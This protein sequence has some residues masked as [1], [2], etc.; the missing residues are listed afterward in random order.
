MINRRFLAIPALL[1]LALPLLAQRPQ[2]RMVQLPIDTPQALLGAQT[3]SHKAAADVLHLAISLPFADPAGAQQFADSVSDPSS[4]NYRQFAT[5]EEIGRRFGLSEANVKKVSD[6]L[7]SQGM[8]VT[9]VGKNRLSI[10][11]DATVGQAEKAFGVSIGNFKPKSLKVDR[12]QGFFSYTT[13]P[14]LPADIAPYVIDIAGLENYTR[15]QRRMF[16]TP[17]QIRSV[18][19]IKPMFDAGF[20]GEGRN[21]AISN[22]DGFRLSNIAPFLTQFG[23]PAPAAGAATNVT[24][25]TIDGGSGTGTQQGEAD[26]D[27]QTILAIAPLCNLIIYDGVNNPVNVLTLETNDNLADII[28]ESYGW[29]FG[30]QSTA[31]SCHN[32]HVSMTG[33]G[34]TYMAASGDSG[35]SVADFPYP[36]YDPEVLM[37]GGTTLTVDSAGNRATETGWSGSGGGWFPSTDTFNTLPSWLKG[38]GIPTNIPFRIFPDVA[39]DADPNTG[40]VV[41]INGSFFQIG[42]TS[43]ASPSY[44]GALGV[45]EQKLINV[46]SL[47][48]NGAGKNRFGRIQDLLYSFNGDSSIFFDITSGSNGTLPNGSTSNAVAG[49]DMVTGWGAFNFNGFVAKQSVTA[50]VASIVGN[51]T[52]IVGGSGSQVQFTVTL[53]A[54]APTGGAVIAL[55]S[56]DAS[57]PVPANVTVLA[58]ATTAKINVTTKDVSATKTVTVKATGPTNNATTTLT[59][60]PGPTTKSLT[61][62]PFQVVGGSVTVVTGKVTLNAV[63]PTGGMNVVL[64]SA[65]TGAATVPATV[66]VPAGVDNATFTVTHKSVPSTT[67]VAI[68]GKSGGVT[69]SANLTLKQPALVLL[70]L[71]VASALGGATATGSI[72]L[73]VPAPVGGLTVA[74]STSD[75]TLVDLSTSSLT[76]PAGSTKATF[77]IVPKP[78]DAAKTITINA[79]YNGVTKSTT[80]AL[81]TPSMAS[82][83]PSKTVAVGG[84]DT[85]TITVNLDSPAGPSGVNVALSVAPAAA[86]IIPTTLNIASGLK[87]GTATFTA[88]AVNANTV[89]KVSATLAI[90]RSANITVTAGKLSTFTLSPTTGPGGTKITGTVTLTAP[91]GTGGR[92]VTITSTDTTN[93]PVPASVTVPKGA[94]SV[95]FTATPKVVTANKVVTLKVQLD[96]ARLGQN[97][98]I[99]H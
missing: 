42:G 11:A 6:Y 71:N 4:P 78:V 54:A 3:V 38:Q 31:L 99:T 84:V 69:S 52:T 59:V 12:L 32:L 68:S 18:Y 14:T 29:R 67:V 17:D 94:T 74:L 58:G 51:K 95:T 88:S 85:V 82:I 22:Y 89:G 20:R 75:P 10:L 19:S 40:Y 5:P 43:G 63:A 80:L 24:V 25:K 26:L 23:L 27:I 35:T 79:A 28:S 65:N 56:T 81:K 98:T 60:T 15:P 73:S 64:S 44:A 92:V 72:T 66:L 36:N 13:P 87:T 61:L 86:G 70:K 45:S 90:T 48:A 97:F 37:V 96:T 47:P 8:K 62:T 91:A 57:V 2:T 76:V 30:S 93:L 77:T 1:T 16:V 34:I 39:L 46:G 21:I 53:Q 50:K 41:F 49:W 55:S 9:L 83:V 7:V 33:Q